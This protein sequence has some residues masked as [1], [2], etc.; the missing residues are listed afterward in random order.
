MPTRAAMKRNPA[1]HSG[2]RQEKVN[3][4]TTGKVLKGAVIFVI[5][6]T[7][8]FC[9]LIEYEFC[10]AKWTLIVRAEFDRIF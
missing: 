3:L 2:P 7:F 9:S 1:S 4:A 6:D 10:G 5:L 8:C